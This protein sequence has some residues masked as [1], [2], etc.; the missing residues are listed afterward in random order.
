MSV[1][2]SAS[3]ST[4]WAGSHASY[5]NRLNQKE[6]CSGHGGDQ[7]GIE[8]AMLIDTEKPTEEIPEPRSSQEHLL[9]KLGEDDLL[10][11]PSLGA[12]FSL[13]GPPPAEQQGLN[14]AL[15]LDDN[16]H[17]APIVGRD[18]WNA[19]RSPGSCE[20]G[21]QAPVFSSKVAYNAI[22]LRPSISSSHSLPSCARQHTTG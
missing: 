18:F 15:C 17:G 9:A 8:S 3:I 7:C 13:P 14:P 2:T 6:S 22:G 1:A 10:I 12:A 11:R 5:R 4:T 19:G 20:S 16:G 21:R